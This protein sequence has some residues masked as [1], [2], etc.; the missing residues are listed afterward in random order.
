[1]RT[2]LL[3]IPLALLPLLSACSTAGAGG[4]ESVAVVDTLPASLFTERLGAVGGPERRVADSLE[5]GRPVVLV[6]WQSWC[7]SCVAEAPELAAAARE[8]TEF[9]FYGIVSGPAGK[10]DEFAVAR[11]AGELELPYPNLRD[12]SLLLTEGLGVTGTPTIGPDRSLRYSGHVP[13]ADWSALR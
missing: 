9:D 1:M 8:H 12:T 3:S 10:V 4:A 11:I 13:P 6:F 5:A 7:G 2:L